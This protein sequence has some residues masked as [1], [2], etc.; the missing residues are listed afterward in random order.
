[1]GG[2][3]KGGTAQLSVPAELPERLRGFQE[4][5]L[6]SFAAQSSLQNTP[7]AVLTAACVPAWQSPRSHSL[8][9]LSFEFCPSHSLNSFPFLW[10]CI[11]ESTAIR[12]SDSSPNTLQRARARRR[13][14]LRMMDGGRSHAYQARPCAGAFA[15]GVS[16]RCSGPVRRSSQAPLHRS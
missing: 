12:D 4:M 3:G 14:P 13:S 2:G 7:P 16:P 15:R 5:G 10:A 1:M 6:Y 9:D 8:S 11:T